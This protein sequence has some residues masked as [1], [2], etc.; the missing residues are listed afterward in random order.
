MLLRHLFSLTPDLL[1]EGGRDKKETKGEGDKE[2]TTQPVFEGGS[3]NRLE[4][5]R[6]KG[7]FGLTKHAKARSLP[8]YITIWAA[9]EVRNGNP[10]KKYTPLDFDLA[11]SPMVIKTRGAD[12]IAVQRNVLQVEVKETGFKLQVTGFDMNRDLRIKIKP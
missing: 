9:Y 2:G 1:K 3:A 11:K 12:I 7:G 6:V 8:R 4:L 10:F 5:H